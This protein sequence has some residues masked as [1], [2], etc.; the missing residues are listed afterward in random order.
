MNS[1]MAERCPAFAWTTAYIAAIAGGDVLLRL[2]ARSTDTTW[3]GY[4]ATVSLVAVSASAVMLEVLIS[5]GWSCEWIE[6]LRS[7]VVIYA[8][9]FIVGIFVWS[10]VTVGYHVQTW[11]RA[12]V[13]GL[14]VAPLLALAATHSTHRFSKAL[15]VVAGLPLM[16][17]VLIMATLVFF[18]ITN[19]L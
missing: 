15:R 16:I 4:P 18:A 1:Q 14:F 10:G 17:L 19:H 11:Y 6:R 3:L 12:A 8:L 13:I 7:R 2:A 9:S 5:R